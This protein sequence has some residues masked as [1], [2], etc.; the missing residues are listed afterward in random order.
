MRKSNKKCIESPKILPK[1]KTPGWLVYND[2]IEEGYRVNYNYISCSKSLCGMHNETM[3]IWTHSIGALIF[4]ILFFQ[5]LVSFD[6]FGIYY[7]K[8]NSR[9]RKFNFENFLKKS[10]IKSN[11]KISVKNNNLHEGIKGINFFNE[12][13][14]TE[15]GKYLFKSIAN[16][17]DKNKEMVKFIQEKRME[18]DLNKNMIKLEIEF[19]EKF[20]K[21]AE[22]AFEKIDKN[23]K[24]LMK[25]IKYLE[26]RF[27]AMYLERVSLQ[28]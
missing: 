3:N 16:F 4:L 1:S 13:L 9:F 7:E 15:N 12:I 14:E 19:K 28:I 20:S 22:I 27:L 8:F 26:S 6:P 17:L 10:N 11:F 23:K 25:K 2:Y 21:M 18:F 5:T 24:Y